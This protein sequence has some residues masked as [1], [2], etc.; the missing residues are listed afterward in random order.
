MAMV[1]NCAIFLVHHLLL[2]LSA[3]NILNILNKLVW[4]NMVL[5]LH[6]VDF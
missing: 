6:Y 2:K 3:M 1:R 4:I 5:D